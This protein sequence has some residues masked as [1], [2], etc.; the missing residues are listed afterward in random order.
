FGS[1]ILIDTDQPGYGIS[2][3]LIGALSLISAFLLMFVLGFAM[4]SH[5]R[6]VVSGK[7]EMLGAVGVVVDDFSDR[8]T[9][10][11]HGEIWLARTD[12][13]LHKNQSVRVISRD[14]LVLQVT[15][16]DIKEKTS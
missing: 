2:L 4:R 14:G 8:G 11:I 7:E 6:P 16:E 9:I 10:H 3:T 13:P 12:T 1:L 15:A 5:Q